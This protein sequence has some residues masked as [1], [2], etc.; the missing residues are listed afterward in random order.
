MNYV[1]GCTVGAGLLPTLHSFVLLRTCV[2]D[3]HQE[4]SIDYRMCVKLSVYS[5]IVPTTVLHQLTQT[6]M[7]SWIGDTHGTKQR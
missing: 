5:L 2:F 7:S 4:L 1:S 3:V 6:G